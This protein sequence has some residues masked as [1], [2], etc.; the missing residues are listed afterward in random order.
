MKQKF[1]KSNGISL[2][3]LIITIIVIIILAAIVIT[4]SGS[5]VDNANFAKFTSEFDDYETVVQQ[6]F[7]KRYS[8]YMIQGK[9]ITNAQIYYMIAS[10]TELAEYVEPTP[11]GKVSELG[12]TTSPSA[13]EGT[14]YYEITSDTNISGWEKQKSFYDPSEKHYV[15]DMGEVFILPGYGLKQEDTWYVNAKKHYS[16]ATG[17]TGGSGSGSGNNGGN[18]EPGGNNGGNEEP[19]EPAT[20]VY[21]AVSVGDYIEYEGD[22]TTYSTNANNTG[23]T[24]QTITKETPNWQ[25]L[26]IEGNTVYITATGGTNM[27]S[28]DKVYLSGPKG[29]MNGSTELDNICEALYSNSTLGTTARSMTVDDLNKACNYTPSFAD[30]TRYAYYPNGT[31]ITTTP[32]VT[33]KGNTYQKKAVGTT[34]Y[35]G[36]TEHRFYVNSEESITAV[37]CA[38]T[39]YTDANGF[40]YY[41]PTAENPVYVTKTFYKYTPSTQNSTVGAILKGEGSTSDYGWLAASLCVSVDT[42]CARFGM[43]LVSSDNLGIG[44]LANSNGFADNRSYGLRPVV[45]LNSTIQIDTSAE[46]RDGSAEHPWKI[47]K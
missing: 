26:Y 24:S 11:T 33:Y 34:F 14:E 35:S 12:F 18:E 6:D 43:R 27:A 23:Y 21:S 19:Q 15:T 5:M 45:P 42:T 46:G 37:E 9:H 47:T 41:T 4:R 40:D 39:L 22:G 13:L 10:G 17:I 20:P 36:F 3:A 2:I 28:A 7:S 44:S 32:T 30:A 25:V 1:S 16:S 8:K 31:D 29:Y 38:G